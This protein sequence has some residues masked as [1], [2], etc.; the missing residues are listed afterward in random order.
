LVGE[1]LRRGVVQA[2]ALYI[3]VAWGGTE[4]L[5]TVGDRFDWPDWIADAALIL[6]LTGLPFV[7]V[8]AWTFNLSSGALHRDGPGR[9]GGKFLIAAAATIVIGVTASFAVFRSQDEE[10]AVLQEP[11]IA[12]MPIQDFSGSAG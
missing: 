4:I 8:L 1:L 2:V 6:F 3:A 10:I 5:I 11:V 9:L 7:I 12:V